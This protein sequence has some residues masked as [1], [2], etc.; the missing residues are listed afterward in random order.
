M[1]KYKE[2]KV[3]Q[4]ISEND[5]IERAKP[6]IEEGWELVGPPAFEVVFVNQYNGYCV[7]AYGIRRELHAQLM[8]TI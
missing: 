8:A 4:G 5:L 1:K 2:F 3:I 6:L 7:P